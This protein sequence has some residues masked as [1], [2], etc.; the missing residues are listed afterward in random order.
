VWDVPDLW[1]PLALRY[2]SQAMTKTERL[3]GWSLATRVM[4]LL[5]GFA[6]GMLLCLVVFAVVAGTL[7]ARAMGD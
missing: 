4:M 3:Q 7:L 5:A 1:R 6:L 2:R